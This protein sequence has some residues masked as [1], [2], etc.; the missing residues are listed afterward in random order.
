MTEYKRIFLDT[1]PIIYLLEK[2]DPYYGVIQNFF[3]DFP[4][5]DY[6]SSVISRCEYS[7]LLRCWILCSLLQRSLPTVTCS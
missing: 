1:A 6:Y 3:R 2:A 7:R 4:D 5:A